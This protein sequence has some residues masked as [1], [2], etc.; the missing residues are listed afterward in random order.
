MVSDPHER[1]VPQVNEWVL[2]LCDLNKDVEITDKCQI[3]LPDLQLKYAGKVFRIYAKS[4]NDRA[5]ARVEES[6]R[7]DLP[8]SD[9]LES[10]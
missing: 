5:V 9:A 1:G 6:L 7:I 3:V 8:L 4:L 2:K 10:I